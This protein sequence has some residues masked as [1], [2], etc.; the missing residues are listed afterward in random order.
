MLNLVFNGNL[1]SAPEARTVQVNGEEIAVTSFNVA[2]DNGK[3]AAGQALPPTWIRVSVWRNYARVCEQYLKRGMAVSIVSERIKTS[4]YIDKE[5]N[6]AAT[7]EVSARSVD[8]SM[9]RRDDR[10]EQVPF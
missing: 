2:V 3:N 6:A 5:G 10:D 7:L 1:G 8:F 9:N 4:A